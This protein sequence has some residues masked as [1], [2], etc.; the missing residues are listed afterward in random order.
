V[1]DEPSSDRWQSGVY[2]SVGR[3][4]PSLQAFKFPL[5]QRSRSGRRTV[6][7]GQVRPGGASTYRLLRFAAGHW[8]RVG[9][10]VRTTARGYLARTVN[11][12]PGTRYRIWIPSARTYSAILTVR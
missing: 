8:V 11:A 1:R 7:W 4:K 2:T 12:A 10:D 5:T 9:A 3:A 6:L